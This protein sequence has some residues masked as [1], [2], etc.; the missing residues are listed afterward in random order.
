MPKNS[1]EIT[2]AYWS[3]KGLG[4][5]LRQMVLYSG[6]PLKCIFYKTTAV[7]T[8][9]GF[10]VEGSH[11]HL[12]AKP[13]L[14][15]IN[16]LINLPYVEI[17]DADEKTIV[18]QSIACMTL[19]ARELDMHGSDS[20]EN[21]QCEQL[22]CEIMDVR[23][24]MVEFAY[25]EHENQQQAAAALFDATM[26]ADRGSFKKIERWLESKKSS[27]TNYFLVGSAASAAD[28]ALYEML[29]QYACLI[30]FFELIACENKNPA[31]IL[32][33]CEKSHL[34]NL[35]ENFR[36]SPQMEMYFQSP[37]NDLPFNNKSASFGSGKGGE[38]WNPELDVDSTPECIQFN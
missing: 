16:P 37:L 11:W 10:S 2:V 24:K 15:K 32:E 13:V 23:N 25:A 9:D 8:Q 21:S 29:D 14:Q 33:A 28:F 6:V 38:R 12:E 27:S 7:Q 1:S 26:V 4:A 34:A 35:Y 22:L 3:T 5:P 19:L 31:E 20:N 36:N 18:A 17:Q 30:R